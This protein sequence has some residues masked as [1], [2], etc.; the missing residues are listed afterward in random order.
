MKRITHPSGIKD[1]KHTSFFVN[2]HLFAVGILNCGIVH[3][4]KVIA[5]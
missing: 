5:A 4:H 2:H 1:L 3:F